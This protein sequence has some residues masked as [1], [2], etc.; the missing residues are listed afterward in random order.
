MAARAYPASRSEAAC[1]AF[2]TDLT[3]AVE[4][5]LK[6]SLRVNATKAASLADRDVVYSG[7]EVI[8][9]GEAY[10]KIAMSEDGLNA[11][12]EA[13]PAK[14]PV[15]EVDTGLNFIYFRA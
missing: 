14:Y 15:S 10:E 2:Y 6:K 7:S 8:V 12:F 4:K 3:K 9:V 11:L 5:V 1:H 13:L